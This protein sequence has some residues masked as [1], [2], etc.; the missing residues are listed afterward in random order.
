MALTPGRLLTARELLR[1]LGKAGDLRGMVASAGAAALEH[2]GRD[3]NLPALVKRPDEI[4]LGHCNIFE[5]DFV[6]VTVAIEQNQRPHRDPR[7]L[8]IDQ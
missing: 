7:R 6:E 2:Q 3:R 8:H 4:L 1:Q 5:E